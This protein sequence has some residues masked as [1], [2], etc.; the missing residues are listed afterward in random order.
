MALILKFTLLLF[1]RARHGLKEPGFGRNLTFY[2]SQ[3][4][5]DG[6][7]IKAFNAAVCITGMAPAR[8]RI[9]AN[10]RVSD[11]V[12]VITIQII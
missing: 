10:S 9:N 5:F 6:I 3:S 8:Q 4:L 11:L 1:V 7:D 12:H 2:G